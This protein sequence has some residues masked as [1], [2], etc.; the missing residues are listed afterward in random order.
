MAN[1]HAYTR[2]I[3]SINNEVKRTNIRLKALREQKKRAEKYLYDYMCSK[4]IDKVD[5]IT[6]K[7]IEPKTPVKRKPI[8]EKKNDAIELFR[9]VGI[10]C[11]EEFWNDFQQTQKYKTQ[12]S[13]EPPDVF[14]GF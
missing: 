4:G 10:N 1:P 3:E 6:I 13:T 11:P 9:Q 12:K 5:N 14:L 2:E 7:S 8:S